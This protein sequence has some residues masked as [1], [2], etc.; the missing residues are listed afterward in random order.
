VRRRKVADESSFRKT[1][2]PMEIPK[3]KTQNP[4]KFQIPRPQFQTLPDF[5]QQ[6]TDWNLEFGICLGFGIWNLRCT[7]Q[8]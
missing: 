7:V 2:V 8:N 4:N 3:S 5:Y 6:E 1:E